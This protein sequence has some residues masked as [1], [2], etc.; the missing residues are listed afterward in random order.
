VSRCKGSFWE[1]P[2]G[3]YQLGEEEMREVYCLVGGVWGVGS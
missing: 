2:E 1:P 3:R